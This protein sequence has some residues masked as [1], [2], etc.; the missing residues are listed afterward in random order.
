M[1]Y[2]DI[3]KSAQIVHINIFKLHVLCHETTG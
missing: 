1:Q 3:I 2:G